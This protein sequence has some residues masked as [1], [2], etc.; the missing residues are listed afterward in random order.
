MTT[1]HQLNNCITNL[2]FLP[3]CSKLNSKL[4]TRTPAPDFCASVETS[5]ID[6]GQDLQL[7]SRQQN[8][9]KAIL[10]SHNYVTLCGKCEGILQAS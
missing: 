5:L 3:T 4:T 10:P 2:N 8:T 7:A 9:A 1:A 6:C